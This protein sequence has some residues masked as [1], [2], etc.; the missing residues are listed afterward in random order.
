[1]KLGFDIDGVICDMPKA[2]IEF[3]NETYGFN[4]T[5]DIFKNHNIFDNKYVEDPEENEEIATAILKN[6]IENDSVIA[7]LPVYPEAVEAINKFIRSG[8][9]IH[10]ITSR[11][12]TQKAAT[13]AWLRRNLI[14]FNSL[15]V[16]GNG[17]K[18]GNLVSKGKV[19]RSMNLDFFLED[20][21][22]HLDDLYRYKNRWHKGLG[23]LTRPWNKD[24]NINK[25]RYIR[26]D[27]WNE[28]IRHLGIHKR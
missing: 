28:I 2:M 4:Y 17:G 27:N 13:V 6:I 14:P 12:S 5:I 10:Y 24:V 18:A 16:I 1:M 19:A 3:I 15:Q 26:F 11:P 22:W 9:S 7:D 25:H 23:L 20:Y 8:H 21:H